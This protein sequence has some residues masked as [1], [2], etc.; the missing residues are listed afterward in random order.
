VSA[1]LSTLCSQRGRR[2]AHILSVMA[3]EQHRRVCSSICG[4]LSQTSEAR[5]SGKL[6][7]FLRRRVRIS[8]DGVGACRVLFVMDHAGL[9]VL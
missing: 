9:V 7:T 1:V 2:L 3:E 6:D 4:I 8:W 5:W